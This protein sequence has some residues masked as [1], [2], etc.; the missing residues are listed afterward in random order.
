MDVL[1]GVSSL[2][3]APGFC[4]YVFNLKTAKNAKNAKVSLQGS[5]FNNL[6]A[7]KAL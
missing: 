1:G 7:A 6:V 2:R 4:G 3:A 5:W